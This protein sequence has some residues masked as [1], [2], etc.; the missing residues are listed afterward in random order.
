MKITMMVEITEKE[1]AAALLPNGGKI[2][3]VAVEQTPTRG[4]RK[5][6]TTQEVSASQKRATRKKKES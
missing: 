2:T 6:A 5:S 1:L 4:R 3:S